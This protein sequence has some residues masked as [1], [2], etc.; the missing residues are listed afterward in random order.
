MSTTSERLEQLVESTVTIP[1]I[2]S[3]LVE[4]QEVVEN[5]EGS[6]AEAASIIEKDPA[7]ATKILRLVN[8]PIYSL[9]NPVTA[10]PLACSILGLRVVQNLSVQ[11]TVLDQ[12]S[13]GT[14][15]SILDL[16]WLWDHSFKTAM[17]ARILVGEVELDVEISPDE[18][19]T[20]GLI[21]DV[22]KV[23]LIE[24]Q[25]ER[26]EQAMRLSNERAVP[27]ARVE[28]ELFGFTHADVGSLL[29]NRWNLPPVLHTAILLHH[30]T[31]PN[32]EP[33]GVGTLL[34]AANTLAH[35]AAGSRC[36]YKPDLM[37]GPALDSLGLERDRIRGIIEDVRSASTA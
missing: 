32:D 5:P 11:A 6:T 4:M 20:S 34:R 18:A 23:I 30:A 17:A 9:H 36:S 22:G 13:T 16:N 3:I 2:P 19:Y 25:T 27:L 12:F 35:Y 29:A 7:I 15:T 1:T 8:S 31:Q 24:G 26:F 10:I 21:H 37:S 33:C 28:D 14:E